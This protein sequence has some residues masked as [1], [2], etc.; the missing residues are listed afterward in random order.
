MRRVDEH[1]IIIVSDLH[2]SAG[3]DPRTG[4]FD[5]N[6]DFF[7]DAAFARFLDDLRARAATEGRTWRLVLLG[8]VL[9]FLQV[10]LD[11]AGDADGTLDT[12][13]APTV[14]KL[15]RIAAGHP[16]FFAA[17][18]RFAGAG[19]PVEIVCGN[20]DIELIR[21][22][23]Q[24]RFRELVGEQSGAPEAGRRITFYPW[25]YYLPGVLYAE[26]GQQY[27]HM[28]VFPALLQPYAEGDPAQLDLPLGSY[29]VEYLFNRVERLDPFADNV[30]PA[31]KYI[32]WAFRV[33]PV[34]ALLTL[35]HYL[36]FVLVVWR[37]TSPLG[38]RE[39]EA[40][41]AAYREA[42]LRPYA[43]QVGLKY[44]TV[45]AIDRLAAT[46][47]LASKRRLLRSLVVEPFLPSI[48]ILSTLLALYTAL[49]HLG[50]SL[51]SLVLIG[52]GVGGLVW[53]ERRLLRP[54]RRPLGY[55]HRAALLIDQLLRA[56]GEGVPIYV[57]GHTHTAEQYPLALQGAYPRYLNAGTWTPIVQGAYELLGARERFSFV[58]VT[59]SPDTGAPIARLL[60]WNDAAGR[61]EPLPLLTL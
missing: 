15:E 40:R 27:D 41:R 21:E 5:R 17:L 53:R 3:Y 31:N 18:G 50:R 8:D 44:E 52:A 42:W 47:A 51:R 45:A 56:E 29:F 12:S 2:L 36:R 30:K 24:R 32:L 22:P 19:F 9:D 23:V 48:P 55:L 11:R 46:P 25:I 16:E 59:R 20:H 37:R 35:R 43:S 38:R 14:A 33:H 39:R 58:Q 6:E 49:T 7:Y 54:M 60:Q 57:F 34:L 26:H 13:D 61:H 10:E 28:N 4:T 1:D